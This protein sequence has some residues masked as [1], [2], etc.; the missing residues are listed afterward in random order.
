MVFQFVIV[1]VLISKTTAIIKAIAAIFTASKN[2]ARI[3]D[4]LSLGIRGFKIST[5]INDGKNT[6]K[7]AA[8]APQ[9]P[10]I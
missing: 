6:P 1:S 9:T 2:E 3:L 7:V 8:N 5:K 10:F 4:F